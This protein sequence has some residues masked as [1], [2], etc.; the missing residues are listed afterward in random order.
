[1][2]P[3][4]IR[5]AN[6]TRDL[7]MECC[8]GASLDSVPLSLVLQVR[9]EYLAEFV[10]LVSS[11]ANEICNKENKKTIAPDHVLKALTV[12]TRLSPSVHATH[13]C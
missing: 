10:H 8:V 12:R 13:V 6:E 5:C 11:E 4:D 3:D 9:P 1:M 2:L 7:I